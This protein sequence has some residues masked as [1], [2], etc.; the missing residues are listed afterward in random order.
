MLSGE[1][2]AFCARGGPRR[3]SRRAGIGRPAP[4]AALV[5][6]RGHPD[7]DAGGGQVDVLALARAAIDREVTAAAAKAKVSRP[8]RRH[9]AFD[10]SWHR[11]GKTSLPSE[12]G[13]NARS[14]IF[15]S[16]SS[17]HEFDLARPPCLCEEAFQRAIEAQH[18]IVALPRHRLDPVAPRAPGCVGEKSQESR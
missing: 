9:C 17:F 18:R 1:R 13:R 7:L 5:A 4:F 16:A 10:R 14:H 11:D 12:S 15:S 3:P 6:V 8:S 2:A